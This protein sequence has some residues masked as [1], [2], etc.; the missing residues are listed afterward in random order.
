MKIKANALDIFDSLPDELLVQI[1]Y[2][3]PEALEE[4]C[5]AVTLELQLL[6]EKTTTKTKVKKNKKNS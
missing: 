4:L 3:D 2:N 6:K 5:M 1:A